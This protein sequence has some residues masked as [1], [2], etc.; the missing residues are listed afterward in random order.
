MAEGPPALRSPSRLP[1][2]SAFS[3][4][5]LNEH[6]V[7]KRQA[8]RTAT[9]QAGGAALRAAPRP[10]FEFAA[11]VRFHGIHFGIAA[12]A[13]DFAFIAAPVIVALRH[14]EVARGVAADH[15]GGFFGGEGFP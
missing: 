15:F 1:C 2:G 11:E 7:S 13:E 14:P 4:P 8:G 5:L 10:V 3:M 9:R 6:A 12:A